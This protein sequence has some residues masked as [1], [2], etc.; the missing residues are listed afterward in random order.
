[1]D[2]TD[3]DLLWL[4]AEKQTEPEPAEGGDDYDVDL[5]YNHL[6]IAQLRENRS[7]C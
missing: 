7:C 5:F 2:G 4:D 3:D 1:M 6:V